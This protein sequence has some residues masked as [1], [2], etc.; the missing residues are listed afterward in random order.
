MPHSLVPITGCRTTRIYCQPDCPPGR[1]TRPENRVT[2]AS[3]EEARASG[4]RACK[5]CK[6]DDPWPQPETL[7]I[8]DYH[9]PLGTYVLTS[10]QRGLVCVAPREQRKTLTLL[11]QWESKGARFTQG[12]PHNDVAAQQLDEYF[13]G[14]RTHFTVPLYP[15]GT[16]FQ[17]RVWQRLRE[18]PYGDTCSYGQIAAAID[19]PTGS[20]AVGAANGR[21]PIS[22]I[23]PCHRVIGRNGDLVGYGGGI[24]RKRWLLALEAAMASHASPP[25]APVVPC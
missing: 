13:A 21:N 11:H 4:Y 9:S 7:F 22:I 19:P 6:P 8:A 10:S 24:P 3:R 14:Q 17:R 16:P 2:F 15:P 23:V 1:R 18:I 5:V 12:G 25:P 20:R